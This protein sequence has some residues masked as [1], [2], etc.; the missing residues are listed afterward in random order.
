MQ[1]GGLLGGITAW[2]VRKLC[3]SPWEGGGGYTPD[4]VGR[5]TP[6][7]V[8]FR[9]CKSDVFEKANRLTKPEPVEKPS[10]EGSVMIRGEDGTRRAV[11]VVRAADV[12]KKK[13]RRRK[14]G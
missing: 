13:R 12:V 2:H 8:W 3:D 14:R 11:K 4:Q 5:M 6:D 1:C 9:L 10:E 7:Q